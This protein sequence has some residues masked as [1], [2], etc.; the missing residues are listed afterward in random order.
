MKVLILQ[1]TMH[2]LGHSKK[3]GRTIHVGKCMALPKD[4][5]HLT[6]F[7]CYHFGLDFELAVVA[8]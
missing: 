1:N 5:S 8:L 7:A 4:L 3:I 6:K 2:F